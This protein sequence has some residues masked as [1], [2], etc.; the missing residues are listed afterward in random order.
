[1]TNALARQTN[2]TAIAAVGERFDVFA[3]LSFGDLV[4][5]GNEL[6]RTGFL[7]AHIQNGTQFAAIV[8]AG[9]E[10]GMMPM[11]ALRS[12]QMVK[13]KIIEDAASQL[14]RFKAVGGHAIFTDLDDTKAVLVL[15]HPNGDQHTETWTVE[16]SKRAGLSGGNHDKFRKAMLRSRVITA[17]LKS[18]GWDGAVGTY[19]P[20]EMAVGAE[21]EEKPVV[22]DEV[23]AAKAKADAEKAAAEAAEMKKEAMARF[24][25][26]VD[27]LAEDIMKATDSE[28]LA[29]LYDRIGDVAGN[30]AK[31]RAVLLSLSDKVAAK[32][33]DAEWMPA[34]NEVREGVLV[35]IRRVEEAQ[36]KRTQAA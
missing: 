25:A 15:T 12:L 5:V 36:L 6:V 4:A 29:A 2:N 31:T 23:A 8:I 20:D 27:D 14:S 13:G 1:M 30:S 33:A 18:L 22:V 32:L 34:N 26:A 10:L 16:D 3:G 28:Q 35:A 19:D 9:R 7:P 21:R 11:R 24:L 17:G